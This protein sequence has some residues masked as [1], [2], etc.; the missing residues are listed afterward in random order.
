MADIM[1]L[2][3][4]VVRFNVAGTSNFA[5]AF[6]FNIAANDGW[7]LLRIPQIETNTNPGIPPSANNAGGS[8]PV[9]G[10]NSTLTDG[11]TD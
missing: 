3:K 5:E 8:L 2:G 4:N 1:R 9:T 6:K 10:Q 11:V 7:L